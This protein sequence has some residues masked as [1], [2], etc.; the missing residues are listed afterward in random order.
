MVGSAPAL[1]AGDV[2]RFSLILRAEGCKFY[3]RAQ[4]HV[5]DASA[6]SCSKPT[7]VNNAT[8]IGVR[9]GSS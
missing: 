8:G 5:D 1:L 7:L 2:E 4:T 9:F 3:Q 6:S